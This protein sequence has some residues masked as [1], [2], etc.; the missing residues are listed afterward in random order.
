MDQTQAKKLSGKQWV[1]W[2]DEHAKSSAAK[3]KHL[4]E[5]LRTDTMVKDLVEPFRSHVQAF[6]A[7]LRAAG[8][9][10]HATDSK[11]NPKRAYLFHW[12]WRIALDKA[13]PSEA[14]PMAGV[15][16]RWDHGDAAK[17]RA[18]AKEMVQGFG[19]AVPPKSTVAPAPHSNHIDGNA[20]DMLITWTGILHVKK[21]N[22][23]FEDVP[24][25]SDPNKNHK[26]HVV[27]D[28]Y[29]VIKHK[30]DAPHWSINGK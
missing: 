9:R 22:G 10:V 5:P 17:S 14:K 3:V 28:S 2:A 1:A 13:K 29:Q 25:M 23:R 7:A 8:A 19:L 6:I 15:D 18:G 12:S 21:K 30:H 16:I 26:L 27:G 11:R 4:K 20:I 24:F